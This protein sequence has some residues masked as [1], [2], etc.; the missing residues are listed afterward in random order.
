VDRSARLLRLARRWAISESVKVDFQISP[1]DSLPFPS[2]SFDACCATTVIYF[3]Q[4]PV[5]V[6]REMVRVT[7]PGGIIATLDPSS[8]MS[9]PAMR[10]YALRHGLNARDRRKLHAWAI[11]AQFNRRFTEF[12]LNSLLQSA[13]LLECL[14]QPKW[15]GL[16]WFARAVVPTTL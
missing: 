7:R 12:E 5:Q 3:V 2:R 6:L 15:D 10:E 16:V 11:A 1:A 8:A 9:V 4:N 14:L 13:G